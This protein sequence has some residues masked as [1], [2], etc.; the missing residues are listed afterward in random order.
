MGS[1]PSLVLAR[2]VWL[3]TGLGLC[4]DGFAVTVAPRHPG[5]GLSLFWTAILIPFATYMTVLLA[6]QPSRVL[7]EFTIAAVGVYPAVIYRMASPLILG[8]FDEHLHERTLLDLLHGSGLFAPN[9]L[10]PI[11]PQYPGMELFTGIIL[12]LTGMPLM[13]G[14]SLVVLLCRL[15]FVLTI[16]HAALTVNPSRWAASLV[17]VIY[18]VSPQFYFFNSQFAYQTMAITLGV[19]GLFLLRRAQ[20]AEG[21]A[22]SRF[23]CAAILALIATVITHHITSWIVLGFLVAWTVLAPRGQRKFLACAAAVMGISLIIWTDNIVSL[24]T[25]YFR[26]IAA[27][28]LDELKLFAGGKATPVFGGSGANVT[29]TWERAVLIF[30][31]L[32]CTCAAVICGWMLLSR[33]LRQR[34]R[35][36]ALLGTLSLAYPLTLAAHF[37]PSAS[38]IGIRV[39][40][41]LCL[42]L[43][44]SC[45]LVMPRAPGAGKSVSRRVPVAVL[46]MGLVVATYMGGVM[47]GVGQDWNI[48][49]GPY[50]VSAEA[51]TQDPETLAAVRWAAAHLPAGSRIVADRVPADL[52]AAQ[53][54]LWPV[55]AP[56]H[57]LEGAQLYFADGWGPEQTGIVRGLHISYL[58]VDQRLADSLP[59]EGFYF[60]PGESTTFRRITAADLTKFSRVRGLKVVYHHGPVTIYSTAGL[61]A[62]PLREGFTGYRPM[63]FGR[64]GDALW[65]AVMAGLVLALRRR[66]AGIKSTCKDIG[67][68][69]IG[70]SVMAVAV[71]VGGLLFGLRLMPGPAFTV[72]AAVTALVILGVECIRTRGRLLRR[73]PLPR[74]LDPLIILGIIAGIAGVAISIRAAWTV[75]VKAVDTILRAVA[76]TR[77]P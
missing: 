67:L 39:S 20:L 61:R 12:R 38:A 24:L 56:Q 15:L 32:V 8:G 27:A 45:S 66:L 72:G 73:M 74:R 59:R 26:P 7:R 53:A 35:N 33:A 28:A 48:L 19:G 51:R 23:F 34:K 52:L 75:D 17:V 76:L 25:V 58:Y 46:L 68:L 64:W 70:L 71:F 3:V 43:A 60:Y 18:A 63:G 57:G 36:L 5:I 42:P 47:L 44:L 14:M 40:T 1:A 6:A 55:M 13:L 62:T 41:F 10:L 30:Y 49:P 11:S 16:Y 22:A 77:S 29:P 9:P 31:S 2:A 69:G 37:V 4:L 65:G 21:T 54:R 50:L